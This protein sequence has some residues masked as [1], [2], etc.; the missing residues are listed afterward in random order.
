MTDSSHSRHTPPLR[1]RQPTAGHGTTRGATHCAHRGPG[2]PLDP[3][4]RTAGRVAGR[5]AALGGAAALL[6]AL[7]ATVGRAQAAED[8]AGIRAAAM[9]YIEGWY[10][11]D[12]DRMARA[13]H[14]ELAKRIVMT[15]SSGQSRLGQ[16]SAMTLVDNTRRG[17]GMH[18]PATERREEFR[19]LDIYHGAAVAKIIASSWIDYLELAKWNGQWKIVNVLWERTPPGEHPGM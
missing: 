7:V 6:V 5:L 18:T 2:S 19:I 12:A 14:P 16:M 9:N 4:H 11:G 3:P 10:A 17:G 15:D 8:S 13:L 1:P